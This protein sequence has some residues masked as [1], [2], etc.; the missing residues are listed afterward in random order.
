[1]SRE[2]PTKLVDEVPAGE[3]D[4]LTALLAPLTQRA[5]ISVAVM[6]AS[7]DGR[8]TVNGRV[9]PLTGRADQML[10]LSVRELA[11]V[12][13]AGGRTVRAEGYAGLLGEEAQA[14]R[15]SRGLSGEPAL[16]VLTRRAD[17][18]LPAGARALTAPPLEDGRPDLRAAWRDLRERYGDGLIACEGGPTLLGQL[19]QQRMLDQL[20]LCISPQLVGAQDA[21]RLIEGAGSLVSSPLRLAL[22]DMARVGDFAFL[23]Y[24]AA[25]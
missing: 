7:V 24:S 21:L 15:R 4:A 8:V 3:E 2:R 11:S 5:A 6:V 22:V 16:E 19:A 25:P 12:V 14:R 17:A 23:R 18:D 9:G 20:L 13:V 1:M 10:L